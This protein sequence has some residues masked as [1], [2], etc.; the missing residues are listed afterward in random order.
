M[1]T[2]VTLLGL[3]IGTS[4][5]VIALSAPDTVL[6]TKSCTLT[7][8]PDTVIIDYT[9]NSF[10]INLHSPVTANSYHWTASNGAS[11]TH[12]DSA[13]TTATITQ[14]TTFYL[15]CNFIDSQ[16]L[17]FN[18]DFELGDTGF[19]TE[20]IFNNNMMGQGWY[21]VGYNAQ[22][23]LSC[24]YYNCPHNGGKY[25]IGNGATTPN[26][27]A[28]QTNVNVSPNCDYIFSADFCNVSNLVTDLSL[29]QFSVN[30]QTLGN[31]FSPTPGPCDW[32]E[33]YE[34]WHNTSATT[35]TLTLLNQN[36]ILSGND[37][38]LDNVAL[39]QICTVTDSMT[40]FVNPCNIT[41][42]LPSNIDACKGDTIKLW[43][44]SSDSG[45]CQ[46]SINNYVGD[47]L[48]LIADS[49]QQIFL[50]LTD[51][52][53]CEATA[54]TNINMQESP[55]VTISGNTLTCLGSSITLTATTDTE[56]CDFLW[57][58]G[59]TSSAIT[60]SPNVP[61]TYRV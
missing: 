51:S 28:Y 48:T 41:A 35:A 2:I 43:N 32:R 44:M 29:L 26:V 3:L 6:H 55:Q 54:S 60:V 49:S 23:Y 14:T 15:T 34:I 17:V 45:I 37:F 5:N 18:G 61:T 12:P 7:L 40:V 21:N 38:G 25:F 59:E 10:I 58:T 27:I 56:G 8:P 39:R 4:L 9:N 31:I 42:Q 1:K 13:S 47:T 36:T 16:N 20:L 24:C 46:W 50:L 57:N 30:G 11:I 19:Y 53:G 33:L 52:N 22:T